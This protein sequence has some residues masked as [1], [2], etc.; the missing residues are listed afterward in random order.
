M[1]PSHKPD[2][3]QKNQKVLHCH[4]TKTKQEPNLREQTKFYKLFMLSVLDQ[5]FLS[6]DNWSLLKLLLSN[7]GC[8][9]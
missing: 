2:G 4:T 1:V 3:K 6:S 8:C 9:R 5:L 7:V